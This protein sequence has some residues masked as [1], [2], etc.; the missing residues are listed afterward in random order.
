MSY[1]VTK[2]N[3]TRFNNAERNQNPT[4]THCGCLNL[5]TN[6][7]PPLEEVSHLSLVLEPHCP[8]TEFV[9]YVQ[10]GPWNQASQLCPG[11]RNKEKLQK[12]FLNV[13]DCSAD[14]GNMRYELIF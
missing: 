1:W 2:M 12:Y 8:V 5:T 6:I 13:A 7:T 3:L 11:H 14:V 4:I 10:L 9:R